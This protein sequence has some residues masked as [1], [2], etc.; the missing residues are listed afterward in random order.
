[1]YLEEKLDTLIE[2]QKELVKNIN[3]SEQ[4]QEVVKDKLLGDQLCTYL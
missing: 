3:T 2:K 1:M 4:R